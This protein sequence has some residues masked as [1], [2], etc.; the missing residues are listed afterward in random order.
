VLRFKRKAA[1]VVSAPE[2]VEQPAAPPTPDDVNIPLLDARGPAF[3]LVQAIDLG[4]AVWRANV[5]SELDHL[6]NRQLV[7]VAAYTAGDVDAA[8]PLMQRFITIVLA[9]GLGPHYGSRAMVLGAVGYVD[10]GGSPAEIQGSFSDAVER[11]RMR[12]LRDSAA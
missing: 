3:E 9:M 12:R 6:P 2:A 11:G 7:I 10:G 4:P 8:R 1:A 5:A